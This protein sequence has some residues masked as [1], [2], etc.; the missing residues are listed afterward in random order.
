MPD[1][2]EDDPYR[3]ALPMLDLL[4]ECEPYVESVDDPDFPACVSFYVPRHAIHRLRLLCPSPPSPFQPAR[5]RLEMM[6]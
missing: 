1:R 6:K 3:V 5:Q 2:P 4:A